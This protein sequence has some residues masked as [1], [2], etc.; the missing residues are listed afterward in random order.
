MEKCFRTLVTLF[1]IFLYFLEPFF[2]PELIL[3][4]QQTA[5]DVE[6]FVP[7]FPW[8]KKTSNRK[9]LRTGPTTTG[10]EVHRCVD[11]KV[12]YSFSL[13]RGFSLERGWRWSK[14]NRWV[15]VSRG[16]RKKNKDKEKKKA[17]RNG[18]YYTELVLEGVKNKEEKS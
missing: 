16:W 7:D 2:F 3:F 8:G 18:R 14:S 6:P 13:L 17:P 11:L 5:D 10:R 1:T 12:D 9:N 15:W 4:S